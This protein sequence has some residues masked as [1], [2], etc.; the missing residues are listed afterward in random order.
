VFPETGHPGLLR[1]GMAIMR[2]A[3][4]AVLVTGIVP[5]R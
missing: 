2:D 4:Q 3:P 5:G 1:A